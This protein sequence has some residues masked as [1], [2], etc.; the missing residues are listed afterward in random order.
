MES[1]EPAIP[2]DAV[3]L[4]EEERRTWLEHIQAIRALTPREELEDPT[5]LLDN[6]SLFLSGCMCARQVTL[7]K[8]LE[9]DAIVNVAGEEFV[10]PPE[11]PDD[12]AC[13]PIPVNGGVVYDVK[14][15]RLLRDHFDGPEG[16]FQF[17]SQCLQNDY[18]ILVHCIAGH[19]R[20]A[21]ICV[22]F[23]MCYFRWPLAKALHHVASRRP[24]CISNTTLQEELILLA[25]RSSL[26]ARDPEIDRLLLAQAGDPRAASIEEA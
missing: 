2:L 18:R 11:Y 13:M 3:E 23:L 16:A 7:L 26:L 9:I 15:I 20:S 8:D 22:A 25:K 4:S 21:T 19:N 10:D 14:N 1:D 12:W 5:P 6:G 24:R 17:I